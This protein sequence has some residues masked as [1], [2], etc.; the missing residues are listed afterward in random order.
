[1]RTNRS[2]CFVVVLAVATLLL[3]GSHAA[4]TNA[5]SF[6]DSTGYLGSLDSADGIT[7][8]SGA[9]EATAAQANGSFGFFGVDG[10][11]LAGLTRACWLE[12]NLRDCAQGSLSILVGAGS[13]I[14][15]CFPRVVH[16][17]FQADHTLALFASF[18]SD[19]D[20]NTLPVARSLVAPAV[21]GSA[22]LRQLPTMADT[23]LDAQS[24]P[25][26]TQ[27][28]GIAGLTD[29]TTLTLRRD[30]AEIKT[31]TGKDGLFQFTGQPVLGRFD[32]EFAVLPFGAGAQ[33]TFTPATRAAAREGLE[34]ERLDG[35]LRLLDQSHST[36][37]ER[38]T[39]LG[40]SL[41]DLPSAIEGLLNGAR[42]GIPPTQ[43]GSNLDPADLSFVRF[44]SLEATSLG[45]TIAWEG[46]AYLAVRDGGVDHAHKLVGWGW[47][48]MPWWSWTL[49]VLGLGV[50]IARLVV[51][52]EPNGR[53]DRLRWIGWVATPL[54]FLL[55]L[56]F[57]DLETRR[58]VGASF[59]FGADGQA[60]GILLLVDVAFLGIL[61]LVA[62][63]PLRLLL[64][65][66]FL[67]L[68][69]GTFMGLAGALAM[70][71]SFL[72]G[73]TYF[74]DYLDLALHQ[75]VTRLA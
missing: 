61:G 7:V 6:S 37:T 28:G 36:T 44:A 34:P 75:V 52:P 46:Q 49:W 38:E 67:L 51:R 50:W 1:M 56:F 25:V 54:A 42:L 29:N 5:L 57:V 32:V 14:G 68:R 70:L 60:R 63:G 27:S 9:V 53:W 48:S 55:V 23:G 66:G 73:F 4:L 22:Q 11:L 2:A 3:P 47:L 21:G 26:C 16:A 74:R 62:G 24:A 58:M 30:A 35:F 72:L 64:N 33:A 59:F 10:F 69:Q 71:L 19:D 13:S 41:Q 39:S 8:T 65:N 18:A 12:G 43:E 40:D 31:F 20:L 15:L 45:T 17:T